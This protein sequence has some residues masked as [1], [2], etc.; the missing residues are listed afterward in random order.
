MEA[1]CLHAIQI[2]CFRCVVS[3]SA[4]A[5]IIISYNCPPSLSLE[6]D[7]LFFFSSEKLLLLSN[8]IMQFSSF[9]LLLL[10]VVVSRRVCINVQIVVRH[11]STLCHLCSSTRSNFILPSHHYSILGTR[12]RYVL[13]K[14]LST[15]QLN[16]T[17]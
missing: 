10:I 6:A 17:A 9:H 13:R 3:V 14:H 15:A 7:C 16:L 5:M 2:Y 8:G 4:F 1:K 12:T 11:C